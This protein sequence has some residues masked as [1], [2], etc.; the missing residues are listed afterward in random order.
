VTKRARPWE[1]YAGLDGD[2][3]WF[4]LLAAKDVRP[5]E[6]REAFDIRPKSLGEM[7]FWDA[8]ERALELDADGLVQFDT[9]DGW[10]IALEPAGATGMA[11]A[12]RS[13][14]GRVAVFLQTIED[15]CLMLVQ[16]GSLVRAFDPGGWPDEVGRTPEEE[17]LPFED[18]EEDM[19]ALSLL[20][21]ERWTGLV[22]SPEWLLCPG[23]QTHRAPLPRFPREPMR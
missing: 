22:V 2:P 3:H 7:A 16:D 21:F 4:C 13:L 8:S 1:K 19:T 11:V 5:D 10:S 12:S 20:V 15:R 14:P 23:R 6:L 17:D 18:L 9:L